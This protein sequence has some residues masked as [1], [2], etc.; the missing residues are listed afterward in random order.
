MVA[1]EFHEKALLAIT[2]KELHDKEALRVASQRHVTAQTSV[3]TSCASIQTEFIPT[4]V[5]VRTTMI[6]LSE[7]EPATVPHLLGPRKQF[8]IAISAPTSVFPS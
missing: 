4:D 6:Q 8:P 5:S 7:K 2:L 3:E 1:R